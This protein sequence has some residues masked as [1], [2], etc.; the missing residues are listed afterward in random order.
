MENNIENKEMTAQQSLGI[1]T[2][3]MN[4][5]RRAILQNSAKHFIL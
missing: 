5:S 3:M 1:I 4:N 2:E